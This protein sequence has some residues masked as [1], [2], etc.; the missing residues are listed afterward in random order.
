MTDVLGDVRDP[1]LRLLRHDR[2]RKA[3]AARNTALR[4]ARAPLVSQLDADDLWH[5]EYLENV[6]PRFDDPGVGLVYTNAEIEGHPFGADTYI[7]SRPCIRW[8][9]S[10][11]SPSRTRCPR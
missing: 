10:R 3:P 4:A 2:N 11:R 1:R 5:P 8:T 7:V 6:L 9:A